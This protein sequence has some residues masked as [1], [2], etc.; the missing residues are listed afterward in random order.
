MNKKDM[1]GARKKI[2]KTAIGGTVG[3]LLGGIIANVLFRWAGVVFY[4]LGWTLTGALIGAAIGVFEMAA[5]QMN[6]KDMTGA[7]KKIIKTAIGGTVGG[8]LGG[9]LSYLLRRI[10]TGILTGRDPDSLWSPSA[11]GFVALGMCIGLLIGLAQVILKEAWIKVE[12]G[13]RPGREMI[14]TKDRVS[15]GRSEGCDVGLYGDPAVEKL[16]AHIILDG[17]RYYLEDVGTPAGTYVNDRPVAGRTPLS[18]GDVIRMG[19]NVLRFNERQKR[20]S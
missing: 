9:I 10:L 18:A 17:G 16:H 19:R 3:G 11:L 6:K 12:A 1:T 2:I 4:F 5:A 20:T 15:V 7:R 13:A 8:L 14:L